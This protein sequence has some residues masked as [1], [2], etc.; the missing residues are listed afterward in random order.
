[1]KTLLVIWHT[2]TGGTEQMVQAAI[3]GARACGET[4]LLC[5]QAPEVQPGDLLHADA[6]LFAAPENLGSLSGLMKDFFDRCYYPVLDHINGRP[7][8]LMVCAGSDGL[9]A[10]RQMQRICTGWRLREVAPALVIH[11]KA[12]TARD[13]LAPKRIDLADL[14]R[15]MQ[16]GAALAAGLSAGVF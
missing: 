2:R 9:G 13:I 14:E 5:K 6:Y 1:M 10:V 16:R 12:Q 7:Y 15:C 4:K 3:D 8:A 11:T